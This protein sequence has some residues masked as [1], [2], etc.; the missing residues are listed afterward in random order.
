MSSGFLKDDWHPCLL[1]G[2][3]AGCLGPLVEQP[4]DWGV[5]MMVMMMMMCLIPL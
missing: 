5:L 3:M 2:P 4:G 1:D